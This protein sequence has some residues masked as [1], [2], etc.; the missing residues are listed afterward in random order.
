MQRTEWGIWLGE[1]HSK[2]VFR[3][4]E[5]GRVH[6]ILMQ[7]GTK[8]SSVVEATKAKNGSQ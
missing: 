4:V 3:F 5:L 7:K 2:S 6:R 1:P 8:M